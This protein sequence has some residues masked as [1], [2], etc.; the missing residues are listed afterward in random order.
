MIIFMNVL[1]VLGFFFTGMLLGSYFTQRCI[2][3]IIDN[4]VE[5]LLEANGFYAVKKEDDS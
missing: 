2:E 1:C 4:E 5:K 3:K